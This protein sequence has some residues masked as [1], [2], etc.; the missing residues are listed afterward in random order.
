MFDYE[1][2]IKDKNKLEDE[3]FENKRNDIIDYDVYEEE[4]SKKRC[5]LNKKYKIIF[6]HYIFDGI[7]IPHEEFYIV[8]DKENNI[9][10]YNSTKGKVNTY[11]INYDDIREIMKL[12]K[13]IKS[14]EVL[15]PPILDGLLYTMYFDNNVG[16]EL[17]S[18]N[19]WYWLDKKEI[20]KKHNDRKTK[21]ARQYTKEIIRYIKTI[22]KILDK[23]KITY[24]ILSN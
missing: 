5:A 18:L 6:N 19:F 14:G 13:N 10:L 3:E 17:H 9:I 20:D 2:Y 8:D 12:T 22:Q 23:N 7:G 4:C 1:K 24:Q 11:S 16:Y 21:E 15:F